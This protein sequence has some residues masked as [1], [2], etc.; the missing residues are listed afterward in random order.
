MK[1]NNINED[2]LLDL[3]GDSRIGIFTNSVEDLEQIDR[4]DPYDPLHSKIFSL[5]FRLQW[6]YWRLLR[7]ENPIFGVVLI[8]YLQGHPDRIPA[9][10]IK[11]TTESILGNPSNLERQVKAY[12]LAWR[13]FSLSTAI[14]WMHKAE[15]IP[16][17][18]C[19]KKVAT[20]AYDSLNIKISARTLK[21]HYYR[22]INTNAVLIQMSG[23]MEGMAKL[24]DLRGFKEELENFPT[25]FPKIYRDFLVAGLD[26]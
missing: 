1:Y 12:Q 8:K 4:S 9:L 3:F 5:Q 6:L 16:L 25:Q 13:R 19:Y 14:C 18:E 20:W 11:L 7:D 10:A 15:Q 22:E 26:Y 21:A 2:A 24:S 17:N 23:F